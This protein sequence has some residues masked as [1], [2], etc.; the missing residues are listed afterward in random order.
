VVSE[1]AGQNFGFLDEHE[2]TKQGRFLP[3]A[4]VLQLNLR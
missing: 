1:H 2:A 3:V 4:L